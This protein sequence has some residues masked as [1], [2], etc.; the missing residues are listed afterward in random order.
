VEEYGYVGGR[1]KESGEGRRKES[2]VTRAGSK[3]KE[4]LGRKKGE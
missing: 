2:K 3:T 1:R 4:G